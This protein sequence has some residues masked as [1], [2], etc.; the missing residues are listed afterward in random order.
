VAD[1]RQAALVLFACKF[2][3]DWSLS[4]AWGAIT[5]VGGPVSGTLFGSINTMGAI[6]AFVA[7][8]VLAW[9]K[10]HHGWDGML[11]TVAA[12]FATAALCWFLIDSRRQLWREEPALPDSH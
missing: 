9:I 2:F 12:L 6:A 3:C 11:W 8:P 7:S 5:D 4:T 1:G 10:K